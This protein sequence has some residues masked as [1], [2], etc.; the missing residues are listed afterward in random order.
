MARGSTRG[1][2]AL[3][4]TYFVVIAFGAWWFASGLDTVWYDE[5]T[6]RWV[7]TA[8]LIASAM[9]LVG[10]A[11]L[12]FRVMRT[13]EDRMRDVEDQ[14]SA[15]PDGPVDDSLMRLREGI[16]MRQE[17]LAGIVFGP[18]AA[19]AVIMGV[20]A[21]VL[22][23]VGSMLQAYYR[24]NTALV[25]GFAYSWLGIGLYLAASLY[26]VIRTLRTDRKQEYVDESLPEDAAW[27]EAGDDVAYESPRSAREDL[28]R[29]DERRAPLDDRRGYARSR[30]G[31]AYSRR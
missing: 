4:G 29:F 18:A 2:K 30:E 12:S 21:A 23:G 25:L 27:S 19:A 7:Y 13:L 5:A 9:F 8:F 22:P 6:S 14:I 16:R 15:N 20:S 31:R 1:L 11:N 24:L 26:L 10:L 3:F 28:G 17:Q